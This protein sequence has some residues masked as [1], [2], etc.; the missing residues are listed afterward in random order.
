MK[1][2]TRLIFECVCIFAYCILIAWFIQ[3]AFV[4]FILSEEEVKTVSEQEYSM[5][6]EA[7][8]DYVNSHKNENK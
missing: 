3:E 6:Y 1:E 5:I 4:I 2:D 7:L 8:N